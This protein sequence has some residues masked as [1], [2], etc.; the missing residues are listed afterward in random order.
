MPGAAAGEDKE[1]AD[2][3]DEMEIGDQQARMRTKMRLKHPKKV[4]P[5]NKTT[6]RI[7]GNG[8]KTN[9]SP[10]DKTQENAPRG[11]Q[12]GTRKKKRIDRNLR[13]SDKKQRPAL[14]KA[15]P[16]N[17]CTPETNL[18]GEKPYRNAKT[19]TDGD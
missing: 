10:E 13:T 2:D 17:S 9:N 7:L 14:R 15:R 5:Q 4:I 11:K 19:S 6:R 8:P 1:K 16:E 18:P 3:I 12:N